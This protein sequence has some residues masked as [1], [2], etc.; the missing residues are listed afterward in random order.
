MRQ[1]LLCLVCESRL[2]E[3]SAGG[4]GVRLEARLGIRLVARLRVIIGIWLGLRLRTGL[5]IDLALKLDQ[6]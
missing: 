3:M 6:D 4:L 2:I 5:G 1:H